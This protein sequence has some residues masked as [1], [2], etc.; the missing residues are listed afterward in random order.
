MI[1]DP[2]ISHFKS[3]YDS[4]GFASSS[5]FDGVY[6]FLAALHAAHFKLY[7][8]TN[9]RLVPTLKLLKH[10]GIDHFFEAI[11]NSEKANPKIEKLIDIL[12]EALLM[13]KP[14]MKVVGREWGME[15]SRAA[16]SV[17]IKFSAGAEE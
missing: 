1:T 4:S 3:H 14:F 17:F 9:K 16:F 6:E 2:I 15:L 7:I 11:L 8:A 5:L 12:W 13:K 10:F